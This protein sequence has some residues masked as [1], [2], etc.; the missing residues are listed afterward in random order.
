M[1]ESPKADSRLS[2][3]N[4]TLPLIDAD[5]RIKLPGFPQGL[6][7][8]AYLPLVNLYT[9]IVEAS[10]VLDRYRDALRLNPTGRPGDQSPLTGLDASGLMPHLYY[11][12]EDQTITRA[13]KVRGAVVGMAKA[14]EAGHASRFL[15]VSTG[16]HAMGVL[17][18]AELL[19]PEAVRVVV[20]DNTTCWKVQRIMGALEVLDARGI[21]AEL[22][23]A[24]QNF[25]QARAWALKQE[26]D[27]FYLDPYEDPWVVAGQGTLGLELAGQIGRLL[28]AGRYDEV[29]VVSPIGG[30]GLLAGTAT[31]L[32]MASAWEPAWRAVTLNLVGLTLG[33]YHAELGD[34]IRVKAMAA[35]NREILDVWRVNVQAMGNPDMAEG[36]RFVS[37]DLKQPVEGAAAGTLWPVLNQPAC[38]PQGDRLVISILSGANT[39]AGR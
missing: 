37:A 28:E 9:R 3:H 17:K 16:N 6:S 12:R 10:R 39:S 2:A 23:A 24:G 4:L 15:A 8:E 30:G 5:G 35:S 34:A 38:R 18:A 33:D 36:L 7:I 29:T 31:A 14:M 22:V 32:R 13:Y 21:K 25:D 27:E 11:K 26:R 19:K 20:P 1:L